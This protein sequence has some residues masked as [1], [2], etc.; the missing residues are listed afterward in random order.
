MPTSIGGC[1][2]LSSKFTLGDEDLVVWPSES[3]V[4]RVRGRVLAPLYRSVPLAASEDST[5]HEYLALVDAIRVG[6]ARERALAKEE[7]NRRLAS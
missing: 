6:R 1:A 3:R 7:L 4:G 2:A 5:L